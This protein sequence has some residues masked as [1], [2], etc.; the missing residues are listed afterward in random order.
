MPLGHNQPTT[1]RLAGREKSWQHQKGITQIL[2]NRAA[3]AVIDL[4][5]AVC[6]S[7]AARGRHAYDAM[8]VSLHGK[9]GLRGESSGG[10][11]LLPT[12]ALSKQR[13]MRVRRAALAGRVLLVTAGVI[14]LIGFVS[15]S[16]THP[17]VARIWRRFF[18]WYLRVL[19]VRPL[20][21]RSIS[22][23][24]IFFFADV[25]A[26]RL[27][28]V[29][30][31]RSA[32]CAAR[33]ARYSA[34]GALVMAPFLYAWYTVMGVL[35]PRDDLPAALAKCVFEQFTLEPFCIV[36]YIVYDAVV[37]SR[38]WRAASRKIASA[39]FPLW[40][41]NAVFWMPANFCNYY[42]ATPDLR[43]VFANLCSL[44]WNAYFSSKINVPVSNQRRPPSTPTKYSPLPDPDSEV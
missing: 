27:A 7:R 8:T 39:F 40:V 1:T 32:L 30:G 6:V 36:M 10:S 21:V 33:L 14:G 17:R 41:K 31:Q 38:G 15:S 18:H 26:Q 34:Y 42:I 28:P 25:L 23:G 16:G 11:K 12:P 43:V 19:H 5:A 3:A 2:S 29:R 20:C 44:F 35:V 24:I 9:P 22:A 37:C 4:G 13:R